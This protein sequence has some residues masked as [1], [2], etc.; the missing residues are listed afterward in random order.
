[1]PAILYV[2]YN[3]HLQGADK[4]HPIELTVFS[5]PNVTAL[6]NINY[7]YNLCISSSNMFSYA[8]PFSKISTKSVHKVTI[9]C[10]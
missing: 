10:T 4:C 8:N 1:M 2:S 6:I 7:L 9:D 3:K 5:V